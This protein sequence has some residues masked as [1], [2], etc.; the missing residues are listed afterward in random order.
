[1]PGT[2][3]L[4]YKLIRF[5]SCQSSTPF[6]DSLSADRASKVTLVTYDFSMAMNDD[7]F[8]NRRASITQ[9]GVV[10]GMTDTPGNPRLFGG[11]PGEPVPEV[12]PQD[13]KT[14]WHLGR[15]LR[16]RFPTGQHAIGFDLKKAICKPGANVQAASYRL[17]IIWG[18][19]DYFAQ[20][21]LAPWVKDDQVSDA[22]FQTMATIPIEWV[23]PGRQ[24]GLPFDVAEF[25]RRLSEGGPPSFSSPSPLPE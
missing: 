16:A 17:S 22:V 4:F 7:C 12:D 13:L 19:L 18:A 25:F 15:D 21:Q 1:M 14:L 5:L 10:I 24:K 23:G 3:F 11:N 6:G 8:W 20:E 2:E 9:R